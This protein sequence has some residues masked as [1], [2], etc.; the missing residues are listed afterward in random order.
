MKPIIAALTLNPTLI[1]LHRLVTY[2]AW[3]FHR[4]R[5]D[6]T[7][8]YRSNAGWVFVKF[9]GKVQPLCPRALRGL[10]K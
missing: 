10:E 5:I 8:D 9:F 7:T 2:F 4:A 1:A 3:M 6:L